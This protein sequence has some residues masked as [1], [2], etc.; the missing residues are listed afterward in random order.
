MR[1]TV[2]PATPDELTTAC[3]VLAARPPEP[4]RDGAALRFRDL[5]TGG[6][7]DPAG[8]FAARDEAGAVRGAMLVQALPGALG[9]AWPPRAERGKFQT[10]IE[11]ALAAAACGWLRGR[12]VKVCQ[13]FGPAAARADA[14]AFGRHGFRLV[15]RVTHL[16]RAGGDGDRAFDPAAGPLA[17]EPFAP[18]ARAE[19]AA[20][21]L[22]TYHDSRDCPELTG[23]RTAA[24]LLDGFRGPVTPGRDWWYL[25]RHAGD[26]VGVVLFDTGLEPG[27]LELNYLGLVPA[28]RGR[29][30]GDWLVR[31][32]LG[33]AAADGSLALN[34]SVDERNAPAL[35]LYER[36]GFVEYD[37][38]DVYL[39]A[40]PG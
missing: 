28:A 19:F 17:F 30:W 21:L 29:G 22:A 33:H 3:R 32:A 18:A 40:W 1:F 39:A 36:H 37:R 27:V 12:G 4:E 25:V 6:E 14:A 38:R 10:A 15:T 26:P 20:T 11:D 13:A 16:R 8:L 35:R 34:L 31:F 7:L 9:L 23:T 2:S 5:L 24:E